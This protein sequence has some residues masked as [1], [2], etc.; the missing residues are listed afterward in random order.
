MV[1]K[2][3]KG[4][5][6]SVRRKARIP[7]ASD[8][9]IEAIRAALEGPLIN[10]F[11]LHI[12]ELKHLPRPAAYDTVM[13]DPALLD[14]CFKLFRSNP[15]LFKDWVTD[16]ERQPVTE[17]HG[18]L[19]CGRTLSDAV[20]LVVRASARRYFRTKLDIRSR[21]KAP[22]PKVSMIKRCAVA[23]GLSAPV[24][25]KT[26]PK[27]PSRSEQLYTAIR[28]YLLF[29]W[30]V[31]LIPHYTPMAPAVVA[32]LGHRLLDIREAAELQ[33]LSAPGAA[34][35]TDGR[36]PLLLDTAQ[37]LMMPGRIAIDAEVLW[38]VTQ[39]MNLARLFPKLDSNQVRRSVAQV[40]ATH[41]EVIK[42]LLP[43]LGGDIRRF[44]AFLM[45]AYTTLGEQ[46]FKQEFC[47]EHQVHAAKKLA[48]RLAKLTEPPPSLDE[49]KVTYAQVLSTAYVG[50]VEAEVKPKPV[51][52]SGGPPPRGETLLKSKPRLSKALDDMGKSKAAP[53]SISG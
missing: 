50:G 13:N 51:A 15:D 14:R 21:F 37:R 47:Q 20:A 39:Q 24:P 26:A 29:D 53:V 52:I 32:G 48:E 7:Q 46:R 9:G 44:T 3:A 49:M 11:R 19:A 38:R 30:Q 34:T 28:D 41:T 17:D 10:V 1:M 2:Q 12:P 6:G 33:A 42:A 8:P 22:P 35:P 23:L 27:G 36:P 16:A 25:V 40:S 43:A 31:T 18:V 4:Q 45:I 5:D